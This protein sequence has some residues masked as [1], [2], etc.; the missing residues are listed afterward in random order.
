M[1]II[2]EININTSELVAAPRTEEFVWFAADESAGVGFIMWEQI[3][4]K[5]PNFSASSYINLF[6]LWKS[7]RFRYDNAA[8][9]MLLLCVAGSEE[10]LTFV[11]VSY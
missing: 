6:S 8:L 3:S 9:W 7:S 11:R 1:L 5:M 4:S 2:I 10:V